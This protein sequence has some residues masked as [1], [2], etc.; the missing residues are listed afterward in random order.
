MSTLSRISAQV[1]RP[2]IGV[3]GCLRLVRSLQQV[4]AGHME[5]IIFFRSLFK[6]AQDLQSFQWTLRHGDGYRTVD[7]NH[8]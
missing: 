4:G 6:G 8:Q 7:V 3:S 1:D 5:R 2:R